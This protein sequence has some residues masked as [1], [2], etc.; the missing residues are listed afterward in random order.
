MDDKG[1]HGSSEG[2]HCLN[3]DSKGARTALWGMQVFKEH[4]MTIIPLKLGRNNQRKQEE[5]RVSEHRKEIISRMRKKI[6][7]TSMIITKKAQMSISC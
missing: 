7:P 3:G 2:R 4:T 6:T 5:R 1:S